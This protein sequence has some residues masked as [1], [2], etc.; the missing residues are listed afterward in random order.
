MK[1]VASAQLL[2][3]KYHAM[4]LKANQDPA[5][6][7][8]NMQSMRVKIEE[9]DSSQAIGDQAFILRIIYKLPEQYDSVRDILEK[10]INAA[11]WPT[12]S[13]MLE[14]LS[15][16]F[17]RTKARLNETSGNEKTKAD[18]VLY[19]GGYKGNCCN[20][21]KRGHKAQ[22]CRGP[23]GGCGSGGSGSGGH[24][25]GGTGGAAAMVAAVV[26]VASMV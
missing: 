13:L 10:G 16:R 8:V 6:F 20:C 18:M 7:I 15:I 21:G 1:S 11:V 4:E 5:V 19:A 17:Q 2:L 22:D 9:A 3:S 23:G 14:A 12:I 24:G 25:N 26:A